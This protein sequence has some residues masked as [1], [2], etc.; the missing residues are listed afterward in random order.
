MQ[1]WLL[2]NINRK[3]HTKCFAVDFFARGLLHCCRAL[4]FASARLS[5]FQLSSCLCIKV[6]FAD[7]LCKLINWNDDSL[8]SHLPLAVGMSMD[9]TVTV[10]G[11][12]DF[13]SSDLLHQHTCMSYFD[14]T[15]F[16]SHDAEVVV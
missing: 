1:P 13:M 11:L 15:V 10:F 3:S 8:K 2:L 12:S 5:C 9:V 4:T 14:G 16:C 6:V 7:V